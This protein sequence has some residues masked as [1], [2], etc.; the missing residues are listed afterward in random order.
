L[1]VGQGQTAVR[2]F[3]DLYLTRILFGRVLEIFRRRIKSC[4]SDFDRY[5]RWHFPVVLAGEEID[6]AVGKLLPILLPTGI[7]LVLAVTGSFGSAA[8]PP[9]AVVLVAAPGLLTVPAGG[10]VVTAGCCACAKVG[11]IASARMKTN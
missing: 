11:E 1:I 10:G 5:I 6:D 9:L 3:D 2:K 8:V 7:P 4:R